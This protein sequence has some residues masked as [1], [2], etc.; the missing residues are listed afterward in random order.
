MLHFHERLTRIGLEALEA[1]GFVL[2]G[3]YAL[4]ANGMGDRP[5]MDVDLFTDQGDPERFAEAV[6][7]LREAL[8]ESGLEVSDNRI[9]ATFADLKVVDPQDWQQS[10]IQ[11]GWDWREF[12]PRRIAI[13]PVLDPRDAVANK[14][15]ALWSRGEARDFVDIDTVLGSGR[16][17]KADLLMMGDTIEATP[18][19]RALLADRFRMI[20]RH[21]AA[22]F[23]QYEVDPVRRDA[24][25]GRFTAWADEI[26]P[27]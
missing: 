15:G 9:G 19:D 1:Y 17:T 22:V 3:G 14:M 27:R 26:D 6:L 23:G 8:S 11:L 4:S 16:F 2:A 21:P 13:G 18:L 25:I 5:S 7:A 24:M 10:D 12:P 20:A